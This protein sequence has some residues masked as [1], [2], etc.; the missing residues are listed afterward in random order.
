MFDHAEIRFHLHPEIV[1]LESSAGRV[2]LRLPYG[3]IVQVL[4]QGGNF[5][6]EQ[7]TWHPYFGVATPNTCLVAVLI[8]FKVRTFI[9]W[10]EKG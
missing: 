1:V 2:T 6:V 9:K 8:D 7:T 4:I 5:L 3:N 10:G